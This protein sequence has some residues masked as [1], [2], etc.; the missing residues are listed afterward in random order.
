MM[1]GTFTNVCVCSGVLVFVCMFWSM[2][3]LCAPDLV[4]LERGDQFL[5]GDVLLLQLRVVLQQP[6][7]PELVLLD[8]LPHP[9][10]LDLQQVV[11]LG[12]GERGIRGTFRTRRSPL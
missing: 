11:V 4:L 2:V 3:G 6:A 12:T 1:G 7:L 5:Q 8:L 9:A 10:P